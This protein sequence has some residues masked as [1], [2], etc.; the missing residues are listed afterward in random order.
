[1]T[2]ETLNLYNKIVERADEMELLWKDRQTLYMDL[3]AT[4]LA[5]KMDW[6]GLSKSDSQNFSHDIVGIQ[7]NI[8]R[9]LTDIYGLFG[10]PKAVFENCFL[11]RYARG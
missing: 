7:N 9:E 1:M 8:N 10:N 3:E 6:V 11:P 2:N 4:D 5:F